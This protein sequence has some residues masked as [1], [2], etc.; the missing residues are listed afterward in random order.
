MIKVR[1]G[2]HLPASVTTTVPPGGTSMITTPTLSKDTKSLT[3][4]VKPKNGDAV[5]GDTYDRF[6]NTI[7]SLSKG[8][9]L[10]VCTMMYQSLVTPQDTYTGDFEMDAFFATLAG[11]VLLPACTWRD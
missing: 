6:V 11:A 2:D 1:D 5:D 10:L 4:T 9:K 3:V 7:A 8:Q